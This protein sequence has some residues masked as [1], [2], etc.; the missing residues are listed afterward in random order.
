MSSIVVKAPGRKTVARLSGCGLKA[1][2][3]PVTARRELCHRRIKRPFF[4]ILD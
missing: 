3:L 4:I 2:L 1:A